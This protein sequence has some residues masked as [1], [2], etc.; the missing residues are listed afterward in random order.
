MPDIF[1]LAQAEALQRVGA[2]AQAARVDS[3][4]DTDGPGRGTRRLR[5]VNGG[6][7]DFD[8][9]PDRAL[10]IGA[11][12]CDG[13]PLAWVSSTGFAGP[14]AYEPAGRGWLRHPQSPRHRPSRFMLRR[15]LSRRCAARRAGLAKR[16]EHFSGPR[17]T[18]SGL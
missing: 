5:V 8:L 6:G 16:L 7:L 13:I 18:R 1:G 3:F 9:H 4:V 11:A 2:L 10:D 15:R 17:S 14:G 12:T